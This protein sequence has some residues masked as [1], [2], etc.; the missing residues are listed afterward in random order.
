MWSWGNFQESGRVTCHRGSERGVK[1]MKVHVLG[2]PNISSDLL[3]SSS[4]SLASKLLP[5]TITLFSWRSVNRNW[6]LIWTRTGKRQEESS[7]SLS[8]NYYR[9]LSLS[10]CSGN[11][12]TSWSLMLFNLC[13]DVDKS[14][15]VRDLRCDLNLFSIENV[16]WSLHYNKNSL[17]FCF[18]SSLVVG[19]HYYFSK[20]VAL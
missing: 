12:I 5:L 14:S 4:I 19:N 13:F 2:G 1:W 11:S 15:E 16:T 9:C 17:N 20:I 6:S 8:R 10:F 3:H 7:R 18:L